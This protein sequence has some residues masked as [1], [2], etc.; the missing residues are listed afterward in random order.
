MSVACWAVVSAW[1]SGGLLLTVESDMPPTS[2]HE[3]KLARSRM[4]DELEDMCKCCAQV[5]SA[6][7][8]SSPRM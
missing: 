5:H 7:D 1:A 4:D 6:E 3:H 2:A 8:R